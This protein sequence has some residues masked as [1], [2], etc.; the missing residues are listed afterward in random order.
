[1]LEGPTRREEQHI[2]QKTTARKRYPVLEK[3]LEFDLERTSL[4]ESILSS[5]F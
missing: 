4:N 1:M 5:E 2:M 3:L